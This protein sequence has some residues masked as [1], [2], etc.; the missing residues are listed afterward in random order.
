MVLTMPVVV[1]KVVALIFQCIERLILN[2]PPGRSSPHEVKD[3]SRA[4]PQ[5]RHPTEMLELAGVLLPVL[6]EIDSYMGVRGIQR[7][8]I[9]KA[10][11][12]DYAC[13]AVVALIGGD[14]SGL[15]CSLHVL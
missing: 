2:L 13:G 8:V 3:I 9:D 15:L 5:V 14:P 12:M 10:E 1:F 11:A 6:D 4:H 7:H